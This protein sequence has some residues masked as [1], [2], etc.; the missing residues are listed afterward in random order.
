MN[1]AIVGCGNIG[2]FY[3]APNSHEIL[4][5]AHAF[6]DSNKTKLIACCD[7]N[8]DNLEKFSNIWGRDIHA[9]LSVRE[10]L[11]N[12]KI[13]IVAIATNTASHYEILQEILT[14][15]KIK[16]IICEK[17][18]VSNVDE[19]DKIYTSLHEK[20]PNLLIN[21]I[22]C[23]DPSIN[24]IKKLIEEEKLG[25]VLCFSSRV[26]KGLYHNGSHVLS[27]VEHLFG[28]I[29][30]FK[31]MNATIFEDDAYGSFWMHTKMADGVLTNFNESEFSLFEMEII[32]EK[33]VVKIHK[34]G[35]DIKAYIAKESKKVKG[36]KELALYKEYPNTLQYYAKNSLSF[37]LK[38]NSKEQME[39]HLKLSYKL[40][41]IK[42]DLLQGAL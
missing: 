34:S 37:L 36:T 41:K 35:F 14:N 39:S 3:D 21:F 10:M 1:A 9:Y 40:L 4:T 8:R 24:K 29:T 12:E 31:A 22:R 27:L 33:G 28:E 7:T 5:H 6:L 32:F 13:D 42:E 23:F 2:G 38:K 18:F 20:S 16:Y 19:Y 17:P 30:D 11:Q 15:T 26:N 25:K